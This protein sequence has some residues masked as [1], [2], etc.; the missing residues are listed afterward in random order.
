MRQHKLLAMKSV[1]LGSGFNQAC[2]WA[3]DSTKYAL[4]RRTQPSML[5]GSGISQA[6]F[7][8]KSRCKIISGTRQPGLSPTGAEKSL[9]RPISATT[10]TFCDEECDPGLKIQRSMLPGLGFN[11]ACS[12][13][14]NSTERASGLGVQPSMVPGQESVQKHIRRQGNL[15]LAGAER[16]KHVIN[17]CDY[18]E[19]Y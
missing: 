14:R 19:P 5:L 8:D 17:L 18:T 1:I 12:W 4:G 15:S 16:F 6:W 9:H 7:W 10:L 3:W 13:A 11:Q 2:S